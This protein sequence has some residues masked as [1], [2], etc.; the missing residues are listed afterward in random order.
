MHKSLITSAVVLLLGSALAAAP[1]NVTIQLVTGD[2]EAGRLIQYVGGEFVIEKAGGQRIAIDVA[3][4]KMMAFGAQ[5][6]DVG[7][8]L[9]GL[10]R[11]AKAGHG[12]G[13]E[14]LREAEPKQ[15]QEPTRNTAGP[16]EKPEALV[17][18]EVK[19]VDVDT[20]IRRL[21]EL[22][23]PRGAAMREGREKLADV[24][25]EAERAGKTEEVLKRLLR[26]A[27]RAKAGTR[28]KVKWLILASAAHFE[29]GRRE[30]GID[31][32]KQ[33]MEEAKQVPGGMQLFRQ[34]RGG[35]RPKR[36]FR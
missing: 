13:L 23:T 7:R 22:D 18:E 14:K 12:R 36:P 31:L 8:I 11:G 4:V 35:I 19:P 24:M 28:E 15:A 27:K 10:R 5:S 1:P 21:S 29:V 17:P 30:A 20:L 34:P 26:E 2:R 6:G 25:A 16:P 9:G 33:A 3:A 32:R